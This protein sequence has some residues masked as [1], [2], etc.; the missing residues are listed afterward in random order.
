MSIF[1]RDA[2]TLRIENVRVTLRTH[3]HLEV[4]SKIKKKRKRKKIMNNN[5]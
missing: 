1:K 5:K 3:S 2:P 4:E